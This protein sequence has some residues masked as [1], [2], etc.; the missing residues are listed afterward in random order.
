MPPD[1]RASQ[2]LASF[3][4]DCAWNRLREIGGEAYLQKLIEDQ[5]IMD[6]EKLREE[7]NLAIDESELIGIELDPLGR[8]VGLTLSVLSLPVEGPPPRIDAFRC[9]FFRSDA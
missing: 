3:C 8:G 2:A 6:W 1:T 7:L 9:C 5:E 4:H